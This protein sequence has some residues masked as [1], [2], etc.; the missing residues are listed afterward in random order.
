[1]LTNNVCLELPGSDVGLAITQ[2]AA[3]TGLVQW[4]MRQSAEVANQLMS[5]ERA[6]EYALLPREKQPIVPKKPQDGWPKYGKV[7]FQDMGLRY[8]ENTQL[9]LKNLNVVIHPKEKVCNGN[10]NINTR[11]SMKYF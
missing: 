7:S 2:A 6:L 3:L 9:V 1:M 10:D 5:V 11:T 8:A 4:G